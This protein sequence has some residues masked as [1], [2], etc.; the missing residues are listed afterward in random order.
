VGDRKKKQ[1][2]FGFPQNS[3]TSHKKRKI[4]FGCLLAKVTQKPYGY[5]FGKADTIYAENFISENK[6]IR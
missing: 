3:Y 6:S 5:Q 1:R 2:C 4:D